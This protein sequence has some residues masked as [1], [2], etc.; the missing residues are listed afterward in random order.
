MSACSLNK[1]VTAL[2]IDENERK[3]RYLVCGIEAVSRAARLRHVQHTHLASAGLQVCGAPVVMMRQ[4]LQEVLCTLHQPVV[5]MQ[6]VCGPQLQIQLQHNG[7]GV[8][9]VQ[10]P[11]A[12]QLGH[13]TP[14]G[15]EKI[16][17]SEGSVEV[18]QTFAACGVRAAQLVGSIGAVPSSVAA[19]GGRQTTGGLGLCARQG[20]E[21]ADARVELSRRG[22]AAALICGITTF[23]LTVALPDSR[24]TLPVA[25]KELVRLTAALTE[26]ACRDSHMS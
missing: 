15:P 16:W 11:G 19:Q 3:L 10:Q 4:H 18:P 25:T 13:G 17:R 23:I 6:G 24:N 26:V 8:L 12:P 9:R 20:T 1:A 21:G 5:H 14:V 2:R 22:G 7:L